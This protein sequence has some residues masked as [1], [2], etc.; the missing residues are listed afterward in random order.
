M[1]FLK[2]R[3]VS[4]YVNVAPAPGAAEATPPGGS[5]PTAFVATSTAPGE[6]ITPTVLQVYYDDSA[7]HP[8]VLELVCAGTWPLGFR[9]RHCI[10]AGLGFARSMAFSHF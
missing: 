6:L 4:Q 9:V 7:L 1:V 8:P 5:V 3:N 2:Y 10:A